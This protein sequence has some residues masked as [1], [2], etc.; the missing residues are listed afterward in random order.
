M[1][2]AAGKTPIRV[3]I[4]LHS[5]PAVVGNIG[6]P[7]RVNFT[8]VGDTVNVAQRFEQL[9]K[10]FMGAGRRGRRA[11]E[12]RH[13][14]RGEGQ[15][16]ARHRPAA[17]RAAPG[18]GPRRAGRGLPAGLRLGYPRGMWIRNAW[19]VAAWTHEIEPGRIHARTII[20]QPLVIYRTSDGAIVALEDRCP[21]R[22]APL[23][24]GRLEGDALRCMYHGLK[25]APDG[26]VHRDPGPEADPAK[27]LRA[28]LSAAGRRQL[29]VDLDG[30]GRQGRPRGHSAVARARRSG[31][32]AAG[33]PARLRRAI[34]C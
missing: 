5:G 1:R 12:R 3:R 17:A 16:V 2:R 4:G 29:G 32:P 26:T 10:E 30:R 11:G 33:R 9:G 19:Y 27:R 7:G 13:A 34:T 28:P 8:V 14:R 24:M 18:Q 15:G 21:H 31:L 22:F 23:S 25:F 20:D 6:A